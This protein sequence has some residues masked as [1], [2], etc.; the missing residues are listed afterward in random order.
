MEFEFP[1][2]CTRL[3]EGGGMIR[4]CRASPLPPMGGVVVA[5]TDGRQVAEVIAPA[6]PSVHQVMHR[7]CRRSAS[8]TVDNERASMP[9]TLQG[10]LTQRAPKGRPVEVL[11]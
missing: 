3:L 11:P 10:L 2:R 6:V 8:H 4:T 9:V 5:G 1:A 7:G